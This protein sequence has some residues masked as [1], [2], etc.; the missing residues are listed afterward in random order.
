MSLPDSISNDKLKG[1]RFHLPYQIY[2]TFMHY[3]CAILAY[4]FYDI[5][6]TGKVVQLNIPPEKSIIS[7]GLHYVYKIGNIYVDVRC[8]F[9]TSHELLNEPDK[10]LVGNTIDKPH[11]FEEKIIYKD[12]T[13]TDSNRSVIFDDVLITDMEVEYARF[14]AQYIL[15]KNPDIQEYINS[16]L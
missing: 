8:V 2:D 14:I 5:L 7:W 12:Y 15:E 11:I 3:N 1:L 10:I 13:I 16:L 9:I 4:A 6:Q